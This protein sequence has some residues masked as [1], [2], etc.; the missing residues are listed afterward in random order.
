MAT[1][2][3]MAMSSLGS[4]VVKVS[5]WMSFSVVLYEQHRILL[6][7]SRRMSFSVAWWRA[8]AGVGSRHESHIA[9][10]ISSIRGDELVRAHVRGFLI[11]T[12]SY[13]YIV[14]Q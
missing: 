6:S 10:A 3:G 11:T 5:S 13:R 14:L 1:G 7:I 8:A 9:T 12:C 2:G 4:S